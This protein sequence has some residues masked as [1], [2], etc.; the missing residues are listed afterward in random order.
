MLTNLNSVTKQEAFYHCVISLILNQASS[1]NVT[2]CLSIF[3]LVNYACSISMP[4]NLKNNI[5]ISKH[6]YFLH[7]VSYL[8]IMP[9]IYS[10]PNVTSTTCSFPSSIRLIS[11]PE[12]VLPSN[13]IL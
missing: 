12:I 3:Y 11:F 4:F 9:F 5:I 8:Q 2:T 6:K 10:I 1:K 13:R 7:V